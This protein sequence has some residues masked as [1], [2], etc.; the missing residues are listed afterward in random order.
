MHQNISGH[1]TN[2]STRI[3]SLWSERGFTFFYFPT[4]RQDGAVDAG[5]AR[6]GFGPR[7]VPCCPLNGNRKA[8]TLAESGFLYDISLVGV[9]DL[10]VWAWRLSP[11]EFKNAKCLNLCELQLIL[12][13]QLRLPVSRPAEAHK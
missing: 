8:E 12:G 10:R 1:R 2:S 6:G 9:L 7:Q 4:P 11:V 13:D 3:A 5:I